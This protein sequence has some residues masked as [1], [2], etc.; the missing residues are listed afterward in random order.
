MP[1]LVAAIVVPSFL[2]NYGIH[3]FTTWLVFIIATMGLNLTVAYAGQKSLGH[4]AFFGLG[5]YAVA[6]A[7]NRLAWNPLISSMLAKSI[8]SP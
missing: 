8:S 6:I 7:A 3:L 5:A 4:A 2:K 1:A